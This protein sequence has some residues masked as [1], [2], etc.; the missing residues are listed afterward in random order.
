MENEAGF[1]SFR[2]WSTLAVVIMGTFLSVISAT[3]ISVAIPT[4]MNVF[5]T[6]LNGVQWITTAYAMTMAIIIPLAPYLSNVFGGERVYLGAMV[7]FICFSVLCAFTMSLDAML[8]FRIMQG[9]GGGLMQPIGMGMVLSMFPPSKRG[10]AFGVFGVAAMA[11]PA[12]GPT[13]G[14]YIVEYLGWRYIFSL[15]LPFGLI[16]I[17][18]ALKYFIFS[19]R[20]SFPKFDIMGFF[21]ATIASGTLLYLLGKNQEIDWANPHY[22]YMLILGLGALVFFITNEFF[23]ESPL[24]DLRILKNWNFSLSLVLTVIQAL[25]MMSASYVMPVFLQNFKGLSAMRSGEVLLPSTL[26]MALIMP[27]A[28]RISDTVGIKG[29]KW[30]IA[31]GISICAVATFSLSKLMNVNASIEAIIIASSIRN[32]GLGLS[33]MPARTIGLLDIKPQDSQ[34]ATAMSAFIMQ[35]SSSLSIAVITLMITNRFNATYAY[36]TSQLSAFNVPLNEAV[37]SLA[38]SLVSRG[39]SLSDAT[40]QAL[41]TILQVVYF[42]NYITA[43][44]FTIFI[45]AVV[46]MA[47]LFIVA[48]FRSPKNP[49]VAGK[50]G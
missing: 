12:F 45:T 4:I 10:L 28:G 16:A 21:S 19:E 39:M 50:K 29:T 36:A 22:I 2:A 3:T 30:I 18:L 20:S 42:E 25:M 49:V 23:S 40:S 46:G 33:M 44:E 11:A 17:A 8:F 7:I 13:L 27:I 26:I 1:D 32:I 47:S 43:I 38:A 37:K 41:Q 5:G 48:L 35:F 24:L 15:N 31:F 14:G 9:I 6:N 34:K